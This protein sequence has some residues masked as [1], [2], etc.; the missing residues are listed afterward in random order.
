MAD[1]LLLPTALYAHTVCCSH[2]AID[3]ATG[4]PVCTGKQYVWQP[5]ATLTQVLSEDLRDIPAQQCA[6]FRTD[7]ALRTHLLTSCSTNSV[8]I[9]SALMGS[10]CG[11]MTSF[12]CG[13]GAG[14]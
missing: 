5:R 3:C 13:S 4:I 14:S 1:R 11:S 9:F 7:K 12:L 10:I 6:R 8:N 2:A